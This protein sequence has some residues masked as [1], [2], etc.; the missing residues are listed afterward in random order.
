MDTALCVR[1]FSNSEISDLGS[2]KD[3]V[4]LYLLAFISTLFNN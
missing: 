3:G 1:Y 4:W 2:V